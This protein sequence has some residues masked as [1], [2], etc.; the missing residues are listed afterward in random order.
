MK[1]ALVLI[2]CI[3][4]T[5]FFGIAVVLRQDTV[6]QLKAVRQLTA[7]LARIPQHVEV[8]HI[9]QTPDQSFA[10]ESATAVLVSDIRTST[11]LFQKDAAALRYPASTAKMMTALVARKLFSLDQIMTVR[12]EAFADGSVIGFHLGEQVKVRDLLA[13]LLVHSGNDSALV[14]A[15]NAAGGYTAFIEE[16]NRTA[17]AMGLSSTHFVNSSGLDDPKQQ[18]SA[19]DLEILGEAVLKDPVLAK[20]VSTK[21]ITVTDISGKIVHQMVNRNE[22]LATV[23]GVF[24]IKTGTTDSA[25]ENL[26]TALHTHNRDVIVVLL[27]SHARYTETTEIL[28]W[29]GSAVSW[30]M[31]SA[32]Q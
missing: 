10:T 29:L 32:P 23:P 9:R 5:G 12:E 28:N 4:A 31:R 26:V 16:M 2:L 15:N 30:E 27:G 18:T 14:L 13:V 11:I 19:Q 3:S 24:G 7:L 8:P 21:K 25:G 22:L 6:E 1:S 20:L 17:K